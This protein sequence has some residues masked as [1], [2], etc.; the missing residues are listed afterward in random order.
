MIG[1]FSFVREAHVEAAEA[2]LALNDRAQAEER[3]T[4]LERLAPV[5]M[6]PMVQAQA[7]RLRARL[8]AVGGEV[9]KAEPAFKSSTGMLRELAMPYWLAVGLAEHGEWLVQ[10]GRTD[11]AKPLPDEAREIFDRLGTR[12]WPERL[13]AIAGLEPAE[14]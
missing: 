8:L 6:T 7:S 5:Q 14:R 9:A 1:V 2:A 13:P 10:Q 4:H 3:L 11:D 12:A